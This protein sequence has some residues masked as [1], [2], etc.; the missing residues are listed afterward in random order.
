M[1]EDLMLTA[2]P[3]SAALPE[4]QRHRARMTVCDNSVSV[5]DAA[6]LLAMLGLLS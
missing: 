4:I 1:P 5:E 6:Q 3:I 2:I